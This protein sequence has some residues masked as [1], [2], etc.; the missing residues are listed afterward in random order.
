MGKMRRHPKVKLISGLIA[1]RE[2]WLEEAK[3]FLIEEFGPVDLESQIFPFGWTDYYQP[4]MGKGLLR[5]FVACEEL[6][7]PD[8]IK[9][10]KIFTNKLEGRLARDIDSKVERPVNIDP[11]YIAKAKLVLATTKNYSHRIYLGD[12]IYAEVTL[13]FEGGIFTPFPW[14]YP[15]YKSKGYIEFFNRVRERYIDQL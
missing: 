15:D 9:G 11:G 6:I 3:D 8:R 5:K 4:E 7:G 2:E 13:K 14:T 1:G 10:I 12:G